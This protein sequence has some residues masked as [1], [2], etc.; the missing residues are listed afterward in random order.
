MEYHTLWVAIKFKLIQGY[1]MNKW[2]Q[3]DLYN[4]EL[5]YCSQVSLLFYVCIYVWLTLKVSRS[6][7]RSVPSQHNN[8]NIW[9]SKLPAAGPFLSLYFSYLLLCIFCWKSKL[10]VKTEK[11]SKKLEIGN[12]LEINNG[13]PLSF[14]NIS[15]PLH[16]FEIICVGRH[17]HLW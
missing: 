2:G 17:G 8:S 14:F 7:I 11:K 13:S 10:V 5:L 15:L 6:Q 12:L 3:Q 9:T 16:Y 4:T 1:K